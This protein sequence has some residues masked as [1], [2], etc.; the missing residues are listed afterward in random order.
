MHVDLT[1]GSGKRKA[2]QTIEKYQDG[3]QRYGDDF[4]ML[5]LL[6]E[7]LRREYHTRDQDHQA[8]Y[9]TKCPKLETGC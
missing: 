8:N 3:G 5:T 7:P 4:R 6:T 2:R 1:M 9:I